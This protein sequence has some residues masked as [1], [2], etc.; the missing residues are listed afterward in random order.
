MKLLKVMG[1]N[2]N[3]KNKLR[4]KIINFDLNIFTKQTKNAYG[5]WLINSYDSFFFVQWDF[6]DSLC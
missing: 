4:K 3:K 5:A 2:Q 1:P 6:Y